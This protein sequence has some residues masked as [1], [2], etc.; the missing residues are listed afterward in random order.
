ML[1][2]YVEL[3]LDLPRQDQDCPFLVARKR[4]PSGLTKALYQSLQDHER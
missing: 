2:D 4:A 3:F 1:H